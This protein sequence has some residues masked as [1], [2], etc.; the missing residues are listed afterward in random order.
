MHAC[1]CAQSPRASHITACVRS[2]P[3]TASCQ[4]PCANSC[5][6]QPAWT[7]CNPSAWPLLAARCA[8]AATGAAKG[9]ESLGFG[10]ASPSSPELPAAP[11]Q[12]EGGTYYGADACLSAS[13]QSGRH[14]GRGYQGVPLTKREFGEVRPARTARPAHEQPQGHARTHTHTRGTPQAGAVAPAAQLAGA[15]LR[16]HAL[17]TCLG[18]T[19]NTD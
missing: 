15:D 9:V 6:A 1:V 7:S 8:R 10:T 14:K 2:T 11:P 13:G 19:S 18:T 16:R 12:V 5:T 4:R 17:S 3:H